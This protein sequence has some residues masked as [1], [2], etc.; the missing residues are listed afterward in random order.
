M[1]RYLALL[2]VP[3]LAHAD[4]KV[5]DQGVAAEIGAASGGRVTVGGL[6]IT[7]HYFYQLSDEDWFDGSASFTFGGGGAACFRDRSAE[8]ICD[9]GLADGDALEIAANARRYFASRG[10][11]RPFARVGI[12]IGLARFGGDKLSGLNIPLHAGGGVRAVVSDGIAIVVEGELAAGLGV[13]N[14]GLG[15]EPLFGL[16]LAMGVEFSLK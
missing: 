1:S 13:Y 14:R 8:L 6:R 5:A 15:A 9:H 10:D 2:L 7:G 16:A 3:A 12:G 11:F 4:D